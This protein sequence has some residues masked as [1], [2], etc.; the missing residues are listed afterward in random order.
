[1]LTNQNMLSVRRDEWP[2]KGATAATHCCAAAPSTAIRS[3]ATVSAAACNSCT[4]DAAAAAGACAAADDQ[5]HGH[6]HAALSATWLPRSWHASGP[7]CLGSPCTTTA[8]HIPATA[9]DSWCG[10]RP[11]WCAHVKWPPTTDW[12]PRHRL[13]GRTI[14]QPSATTSSCTIPSPVCSCIL[15]YVSYRAAMCHHPTAT[16][17]STVASCP[18][19]RPHGSSNSSSSRP[20][21]QPSGV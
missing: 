4:H 3:S 12:S 14:S 9:D 5:R 6:A 17:S 16:T 21:Q 18:P 7:L 15:S 8:P 20:W 1:M 11:M 10:G 13:W 19:A 2:C